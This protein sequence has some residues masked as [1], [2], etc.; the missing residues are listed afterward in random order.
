MNDNVADF[1]RCINHL[2]TDYCD[3]VP[4]VQ[5]YGFT[6]Q[7]DTRLIMTLKHLRDNNI[8]VP[9]YRFA[10]LGLALENFLNHTMLHSGTYFIPGSGYFG[11]K[12]SV[13]TLRDVITELKTPEA[14]CDVF[15]VQSYV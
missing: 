6:N 13:S 10:Q 12:H 3:D 5:I 14:V 7:L 4:P 9:S 15:N 11:L 1:V 2:I 8:C